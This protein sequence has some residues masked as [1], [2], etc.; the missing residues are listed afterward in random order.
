MLRKL[1]SVVVN[2]RKSLAFCW[3]HIKSSSDLLNSCYIPVNCWIVVTI[4]F[5][6]VQADHANEIESLRKTLT[7]LYQAPVTHFNDNQF[8]K[9]GRQSSEEAIK[10]LQSL[11][12]KGI[13]PANDCVLAFAKRFELTS[14]DG[15]LNVTENYT[16][17]LKMFK[18]SER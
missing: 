2:F 12:F 6:R 16:S 8:R 5:E 18:R 14:E 9:I 4:L 11:A 1:C 13:E 3:N 15:V 7:D 10:K 17:L